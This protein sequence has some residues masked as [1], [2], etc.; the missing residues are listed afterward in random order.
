MNLELE[1]LRKW[2]SELYLELGGT[3]EVNSLLNLEHR[4]LGGQK[5]K[6]QCP[7]ETVSLL[8]M[9]QALRF[10]WTPNQALSQSFDSEQFVRTKRVLLWEK[11]FITSIN[12]YWTKQSISIHCTYLEYAYIGSTTLCF[13]WLLTQEADRKFRRVML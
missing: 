2:R 3:W 4:N 1:K 12:V 7:Y 9:F 8:K 10:W 6:L 13:I 11:S 5:C